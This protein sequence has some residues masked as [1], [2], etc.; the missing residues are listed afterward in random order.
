MT[1]VQ[2]TEQIAA[3]VESVFAFVDDH[4]NTTKYMKDL[5]RWEPVDPKKIHGKG[6]TFAVAMTAGPLK[7]ESVVE[8]DGWVENREIAWHS[9]S[10]L[11][12]KG[13]WSFKASRGGTEATFNLEYEPPGGIAGR[14]MARPAEPVVR[15][16]VQRSVRKLGEL[17]LKQGGS[18]TRTPAAAAKS[19]AAPTKP[20][21]PAKPAKPAAAAR[22][23]TTAK[24]SPA[25]RP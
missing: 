23:T 2:H 14:I 7:L 24:R 22:S 4:R 10:G 1:R 17:V 15:G 11:K 13:S 20:A 8:M 16:N 5:S 21:A 18:G 12:Q 19:A 9:I 25:K 3:P 6:A